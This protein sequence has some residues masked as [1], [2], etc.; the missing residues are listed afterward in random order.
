MLAAGCLAVYGSIAQAL[1]GGLLG[2][3]E[4]DVQK[5]FGVEPLRRLKDSWEAQVDPV[6]SLY[7]RLRI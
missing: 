7:R 6:V 4:A 1:T 3:K 2:W 5:D